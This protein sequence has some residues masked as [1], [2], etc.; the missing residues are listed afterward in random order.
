MCAGQ[1]FL[2]PKVYRFSLPTVH[3]G[4][5]RVETG[6]SQGILGYSE[7]EISSTTVIGRAPRMQTL[8]WESQ[9]HTGRAPASRWG[10]GGPQSRG[11]NPGG[12]CS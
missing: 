12:P 3:A 2:I 10:E 11:P 7:T 1:T 5:E 4:H 8:R 6:P 9:R